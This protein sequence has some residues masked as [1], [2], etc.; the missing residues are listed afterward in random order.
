MSIKEVHHVCIQTEKYKE[1][2]K[3]YTEILG[4]ELVEETPDFHD[5]E[6]NTWLKMGAFMIELQTGKKGEDLI[7]CTSQAEGI[8]HMCFTVDDINEEVAR[9]KSMGYNNFK[10][11]YGHEIYKVGDRELCKII[12]P[13]G[14]I[15]EIREP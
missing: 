14:T 10:I 4:F 1:S 15:I 13:E 11:K 8:V 9:I 3:F 2:L 6:Y 12:A 5:R 7:K